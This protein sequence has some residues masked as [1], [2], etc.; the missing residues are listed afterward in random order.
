MSPQT[1]AA[2]RIRPR[3][4]REQRRSPIVRAA[5]PRRAAVARVDERGHHARRAAADDRRT[6]GTRRCTAPGSAPT[7]PASEPEHR[8]TAPAASTALRSRSTDQ[9][10]EGATRRARR[11]AASSDPRDVGIDRALEAAR[12]R[13]SIASQSSPSTAAIDTATRGPRE[14]GARGR[15]AGSQASSTNAPDDTISGSAPPKSLEAAF[16]RQARA[17]RPASGTM[18]ARRGTRRGPRRA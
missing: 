1:P 18:S 13:R 2:R 4:R 12:A 9:P 11:R 3:S 6:R 10:A 15:P 16:R 5:P 7:I 17:G 14:L 8:G